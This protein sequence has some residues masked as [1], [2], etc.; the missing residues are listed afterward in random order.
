MLR[1]TIQQTT[2]TPLLTPFAY[3]VLLLY[4]I[5][6]PGTFIQPLA[7]GSGGAP[8]H[9][10]AAGARKNREPNLSQR[11]VIAPF[12]GLPP[13]NL[14]LRSAGNEI[15]FSQPRL[16]CFVRLRN[17]IVGT[18]VKNRRD[19]RGRH[20]IHADPSCG[21]GRMLQEAQSFAIDLR[22]FILYS[23]KV[24]IVPGGL[25]RVA[26]RD[27]SLVVNSSQGGGSK[28]TWVLENGAPRE[29]V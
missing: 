29:I 11:F 14:T 13:V 5:V 27:G 26:L 3:A 17:G 20:L 16:N 10:A 7:D 24:T 4:L 12:A 28:D 8:L 22:P 9:T 23:E 15:A 18:R 6:A 2:S 25:T 19:A 21:A 1:K